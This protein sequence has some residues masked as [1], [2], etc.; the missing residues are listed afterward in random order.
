M[1]AADGSLVTFKGS[2]KMFGKLTRINFEN[3]S[4]EDGKLSSVGKDSIGKYSISGNYVMD[5]GA[6]FLI[7]WDA[8]GSMRFQG[9]VGDC[10]KCEGVWTMDSGLTGSFEVEIDMRP[11]RKDTE[12]QRFTDFEEEE[13]LKRA[14]MTSEGR[15]I[16]IS[17]TIITPEKAKCYVKAS[18]DWSVEE[19]KN[20]ISEATQYFLKSE[21]V[22]STKKLHGCKA[23]AKFGTTV[24][25][26]G[27][28]HNHSRFQ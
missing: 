2:Y 24:S 10:L 17:L 13:E 9:A 5:T 28:I 19:L 1:S 8:R 27:A 20:S 16:W 26:I 21:K 22:R 11:V 3:V 4:W 7:S 6:D 14:M 23:G 12:V 25:S 15:Q 18:L